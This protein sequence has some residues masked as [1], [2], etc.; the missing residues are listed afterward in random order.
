MLRSWNHVRKSPV[1]VERD[2]IKK[3]QSSHGS[4]EQR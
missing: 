4:E 1:F 3:A 2:L